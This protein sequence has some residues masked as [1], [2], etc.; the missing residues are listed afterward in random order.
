MLFSE[1]II[2]NTVSLHNNVDDIYICPQNCGKSYKTTSSL[3]KHMKYECNTIP[4]FKCLF[5]EKMVKRP[6]NLKKHMRLVHGYDPRP[7]NHQFKN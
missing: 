7:I 1:I 4:Q 3:K 5:C 6:D 2:L